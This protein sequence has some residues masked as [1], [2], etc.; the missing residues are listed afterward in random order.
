MQMGVLAS[1]SSHVTLPLNPHRHEQKNSA[2]HVCIVSFKTCPPS[3]KKVYA[4]VQNHKPI[5]P[6]GPPK[7]CKVWGGRGGPQFFLVEIL[8]FLL[9]RTPCQISKPYDKPFWKK[10]NKGGKIFAHADGGPRSRVCSRDTPAQPPID[11]REKNL[12]HM[13]AKSSKNLT[14]IF[15]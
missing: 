1:V 5:T 7:K 4:K 10:S 13:S 8:I 12:A 3:H 11:M 6:P 2:A 15:F 9:L 14:K